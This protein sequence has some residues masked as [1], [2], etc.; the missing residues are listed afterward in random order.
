MKVLGIDP[1]S[2]RVGLGL[3]ES[4][5]D[6]IQLITH[7]L[8]Q[9]SPKLSHPERLFKV[10]EKLSAF[11]EEHTPHVAVVEKAFYG[12]NVQTAIKMG[13]SRGAIFIA[14]AKRQVPLVEYTPREVKKALTGKGN[15]KKEA[16][17]WMVAGMLGIPLEQLSLDESDALAL[18]ICHHH[19]TLLNYKIG[20]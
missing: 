7:C 5:G 3:V 12:K 1:G 17:Q 9:F 19:R 8:L 18:A 10:Y 2:L 13:E 11:L 4:Q 14:L 6:S 20:R 16:V 15:A